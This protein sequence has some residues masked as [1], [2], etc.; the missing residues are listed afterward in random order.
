MRLLLVGNYPLDRQNSMLRY[1]DLLQRELSARGYVVGVAAPKTVWGGLGRPGALAK[2]LGYV[3][4]YLLFP[5]QL[6][7]LARGWDWVHVCD[8]SNAVYLPYLPKKRSSITCHDLLAIEAAEGRHPVADVGRRVG[9]TGQVQQRW[10]AKHLLRARRVVCISHSTARSRRALGAA[11]EITV[12]HN[13]L[14]RSFAPQPQEE[15]ERCRAQAGLLP[16]EPYV[17]HVGGN[18]WYKNRV[19]VLRIFGALRQHAAGAGLRLVMAGHPWTEEMRLGA[20]EAGLND[21]RSAGPVLTW[22][23]PTDREVEALYTGATLLLFPSLQEGF[24]WPILEAQSCGCAVA[25]SDRDPMREIA[26][27]AAIL[28]DP[29]D[30]VSA[31]DTIAAAWDQLPA[32]RQQG[33]TNAE[34]YS[35]ARLM[36]L[37]DAFFQTAFS[38]AMEGAVANHAA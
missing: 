22:Q 21:D 16:G 25:T 33:L 5:W 6:R 38:A 23:D 14:S 32:L 2:W 35:A 26:G 30:A 18:L 34:L 11:G 1:Q 8:H 31:A 4:K 12:I 7:T 13:P 10:I 24:G 3:D 29:A 36:P 19:G 15:V 17:L 28:L 9:R 20:Q 27:E 37:Y